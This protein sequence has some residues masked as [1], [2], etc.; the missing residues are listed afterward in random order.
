M[1]LSL[2]TPPQ[3]VRAKQSWVSDSVIRD[4]PGMPGGLAGTGF[5][6]EANPARLPRAKRGEVRGSPAMTFSCFSAGCEYTKMSGDCFP[7]LISIGAVFSAGKKHRV[8]NSFYRLPVSHRPDRAGDGSRARAKHHLPGVGLRQCDL[9][10]LLHR[11]W[12]FPQ[13][14]GKLRSPE[15][16]SS[17]S[18]RG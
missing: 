13:A 10:S 3:R 5:A 17:I 11:F 16:R 15:C 4:Y 14:A 9:R 1:N 6:P 12:E 7:A 8:S 2:R 18:F